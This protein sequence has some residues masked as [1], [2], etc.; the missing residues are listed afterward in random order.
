GPGGRHLRPPGGDPRAH[1]RSVDG[2]TLDFGVSGLIY[3]HNFLLYD[4]ETESLWV[5]FTGEAIAGGLQ[6]ASTSIEMIEETINSATIDT[7]L[8]CVAA[9]KQ[10]AGDNNAMLLQIQSEL[11]QARFEQ[12]Q[13]IHLLKTPLGLREEE[14]Q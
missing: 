12:A 5:Q 3:N 13:I 7:A 11:A 2:R 10:T 9:M 4:R 6:A 8:T 14:T 1:R